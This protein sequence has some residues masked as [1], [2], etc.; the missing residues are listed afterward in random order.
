MKL[1]HHYA[2]DT[3]R[4]RNGIVVAIMAVMMLGV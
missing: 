2:V 3:L 1:H 4:K